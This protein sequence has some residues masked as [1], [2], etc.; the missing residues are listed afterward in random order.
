MPEDVVYPAI[1]ENTQQFLNIIPTDP[2][3]TFFDLGA[4]TGIAGLFAAKNFAAHAWTSDITARS[5]HFCEFNRR[6][7][8]L[9]N[10]TVVQGDMYE[11]VAGLE[12]DRIVT[13]PPY[14]PVSRP[15]HVFRDGGDDG[16]L[17]L[18]RAIEGLP[19][20]LAPRGRFYAQTLISDR[21]DDSTED[22]IRRWLGPEQRH[23]DLAL[24]TETSRAP[25]DFVGR[26]MQKGT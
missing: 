7:N 1:L 18:R 14:V 8:G 6:L 9:Q 26:A 2:C 12:F 11:P 3:G 16:E 15:T 24:I 19:R 17:I 23:F 25:F 5:A 13:H 20:H 21:E 10:A 4:G 22:R